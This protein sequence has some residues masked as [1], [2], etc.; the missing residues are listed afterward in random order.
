VE[1]EA[2]RCASVSA[3]SS[4]I[5]RATLSDQKGGGADSHD[6]LR[7]FR[8]RRVRDARREYPHPVG[9]STNSFEKL[10]L[11][12]FRCIPLVLIATILDLAP[13]TRVV[14]A[15]FVSMAERSICSGPAPALRGRPRWLRAVNS[16]R[17][18]PP[19]IGKNLRMSAA[20][21]RR[22]LALTLPIP[23]DPPAPPPSRAQRS[24]LGEDRRGGPVAPQRG[25]HALRREV[26]DRRPRVAGS[27]RPGRRG[28]GSGP[29]PPG[30]TRRR[31]R[32]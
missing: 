14:V 16:T 17:S 31:A 8:A 4:T 1:A 9:E 24:H 5:R 22:A 23:R 21:S 18:G 29:G 30:P 7:V 19:D 28:P 2:G 26:R 20:L 10:L 15:G 11:D 13:I 3:Q 12:G 25:P 6:T 27:R 32:R